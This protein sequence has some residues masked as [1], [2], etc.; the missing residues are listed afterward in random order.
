MHLELGNSVQKRVDFSF[1]E[2]EIKIDQEFSEILIVAQNLL[3]KHRFEL[4]EE[5]KWVF[6]N[7]DLLNTLE[8][9]DQSEI[10][11]AQF[12]FASAENFF[13]NVVSLPVDPRQIDHLLGWKVSEHSCRRPD[14][15]IL[16]NSPLATIIE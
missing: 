6:W 7:S 5:R 9:F 12:N 15:K 1:F 3:E 14:P 13:W 4:I 11:F 16:K 8:K 2:N 10:D